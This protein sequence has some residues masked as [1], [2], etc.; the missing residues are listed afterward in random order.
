MN[1]PKNYIRWIRERIG[2]EKI[3]LTFAGGCIFNES[4]Q[5]LLQRRSDSNKW[6]FPGGAIELGETP[7][8]AA[9]REIKE[10]TGLDVRAG[11]LLGV[12]TELD[13]EYPNGDKAQTV[14]IVYEL[15][16]TGGELRSDG[17]ET[18]DLQYFPLN[19]TPKL[20]CDSHRAIWEML[21]N[22]ASR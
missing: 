21:Q 22:R 4:G 20:F 10:E 7:E 17:N 8:M 15:H 16:V 5:V 1:T 6:G 3:I 19:S 2:H 18:L 9:A 12:Y 11:S 14:S 13:M